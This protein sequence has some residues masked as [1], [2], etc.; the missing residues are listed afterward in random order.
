MTSNTLKEFKEEQNQEIDW[1]SV[2]G[3][4]TIQATALETGLNIK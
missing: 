2:R 4:N 3:Q 1:D